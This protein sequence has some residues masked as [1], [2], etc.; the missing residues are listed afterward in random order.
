MTNKSR[1]NNR[2][3]VSNVRHDV[4]YIIFGKFY[5]IKEKHQGKI[6]FYDGEAGIYRKSPI[7]IEYKSPNKHTEHRIANTCLIEPRGT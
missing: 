7:I 5:N 2:Q 3:I 4:D 6:N 1:G